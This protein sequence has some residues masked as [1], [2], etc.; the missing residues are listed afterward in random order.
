MVTVADVLSC[1]VGRSGVGGARTAPVKAA[2][3]VVATVP[4]SCSVQ[5]QGMLALGDQVAASLVAPQGEESH[6]AERAALGQGR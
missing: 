5:G 1:R 2:T 4:R 3:V 6:G